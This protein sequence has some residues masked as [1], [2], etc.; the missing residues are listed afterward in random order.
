[1]G[2]DEN[3]SEIVRREAAKRG[4][5]ETRYRMLR[6][7]DTSVIQDIV[8]DHVGKPS[9][10]TPSS[11]AA[12][13]EPERGSGWAKERPLRAPEGVDL[14]D[15]M[16]ET[17][18]AKERLQAMHEQVRV[19]SDLRAY[20]LSLEQEREARRR[21]AELDPCNTGIYKTKRELERGE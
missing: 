15:R 12:T 21:D 6:V 2:S 8:G 18:T 7:A 1:M 3:E 5:S 14:I 17:Q 16:V 9:P 11:M 13:R 20:E 19:L 10:L 4:I